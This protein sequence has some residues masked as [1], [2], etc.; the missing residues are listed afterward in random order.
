[1][2]EKWNPKGECLC[3]RIK[4]SLSDIKPEIGVCHCKMCRQW[5]GNSYMSIEAEQ[6]IDIDGEQHLGL[7]NSSEWAER[8][9]CKEC[10]THI[11]YR[12]KENKAHY[13]PVGL[14]EDS[15]L[16]TLDHE[17]FIDLKPAY[18]NFKEDTKKLTSGEVAEFFGGSTD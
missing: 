12:L 15:E 17:I 5:S 16:P 14:F 7:Y 2:N 1:M 9:F 4:V 8:G 6:R 13:L 18:Y 11:F 3:G 10:G